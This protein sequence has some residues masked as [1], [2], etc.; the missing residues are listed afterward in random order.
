MQLMVCEF[1]L[2]EPT[3]RG[4]YLDEI[5]L[6]SGSPLLLTTRIAR[7]KD[8]GDTSL[9]ANRVGNQPARSAGAHGARQTRFSRADKVKSRRN[10]CPDPSASEQARRKSRTN[11]IA[12]GESEAPTLAND[13]FALERFEAFRI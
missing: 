3:L 7:C 4:L 12:G 10:H 8:A 11:I 2:E 1:G 6:H 5:D 9:F 13:R